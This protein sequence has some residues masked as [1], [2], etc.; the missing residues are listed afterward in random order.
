MIGVIVGGLVR[1]GIIGGRGVAGAGASGRGIGGC[2]GVKIRVVVVVIVGIEGVK[3]IA[4][5]VSEYEPTAGVGTASESMNT[6]LGFSRHRKLGPIGAVKALS[7][8]QAIKI[9]SALLVSSGAESNRADGASLHGVGVLF[10][11]LDVLSV[12]DSAVFVV[13]DLETSNNGPGTEGL[14][15]AESMRKRVQPKDVEKDHFDKHPRRVVI[16]KCHIVSAPSPFFDSA[17]AALDVW[18]VFVFAAD[19]EFR[20]KVGG[21][22]T[23]SAL[24]FGV[25]KNESDTKATL[26]VYAVGSL[27]R[28]GEAGFLAIVEN[29]AGDKPKVLRHGHE[30]WDF[31]HKHNVNAQRDVSILGQNRLGN[32]IWCRPKYA[33][34][35]SARSLALNSAKVATE[36]GVRVKSVLPG[37]WTVC[38]GFPFN[39]AEEILDL[40]S[41]N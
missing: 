22:G 8:H 41:A 2:V 30:E 3:V 14:G 15:D 6:I 26:A 5:G 19:V 12:L 10:V 24:E 33:F 27:E 17:N 34:D 36:Y 4:S 16:K 20:L 35:F 32:V 37:H 38:E 25:A 23:A 39:V 1:V 21:N 40:R 18:N 28:L 13:V 9:V 11:S 31:V 7:G 29:F